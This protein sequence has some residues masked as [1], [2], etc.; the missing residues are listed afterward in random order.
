MKK[1]NI[2]NML[3]LKSLQTATKMITGSEAIHMI[4]KVKISQG[5]KSVEK[6][7]YLIHEI[8]GLTA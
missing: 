3:R 6:Q 5:E 1:E 8:F 2:F 7:M 4:K